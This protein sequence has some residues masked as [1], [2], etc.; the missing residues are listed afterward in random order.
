M[1]GRHGE[2]DQR[3]AP[4]H[5]EHDG[6]DAGQHE[7]V[8]EDGDHAGGEHFVQGVHVAGD[9][10]D[11]AAHGIAVEERDVQPLQMTEDLRPQIEHHLLPGPLHDVGLGELEQEADQQQSDV[12]GRNL[13]DAH[14]RLAAQKA[15]EQRMRLGAIG[16]VLIDRNL[17]QVGT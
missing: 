15:I 10:R 11:Q 14:Q 17:G 5:V 12:D 8:F 9:A 3:Q 13:R 4:A 2:G 1:I 16:E 6:D 7:D